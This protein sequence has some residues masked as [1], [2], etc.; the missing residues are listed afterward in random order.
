MNPYEHKRTGAYREVFNDPNCDQDCPACAYERGRRDERQERDLLVN[1]RLS[2][3][4][5]S[6]LIEGKEDND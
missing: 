3:D 5:A 1:M 6:E 2:N 4:I